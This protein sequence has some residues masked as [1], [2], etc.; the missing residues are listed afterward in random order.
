MKFILK[1]LRPADILL[2]ACLLAL[3]FIP[4]LFLPAKAAVAI[5]KVDGQVQRKFDLTKQQHYTYRYQA[6]DGDINVIEIQNQRIRIKAASCP[7]QRCVQ[8]G[9]ISQPGETIICL[10]HK[11]VLTIPGGPENDH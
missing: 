9:W 5:L 4:W 3:S 2:V 7:D 8:Q 6:P 10:P 1:Q 11:L